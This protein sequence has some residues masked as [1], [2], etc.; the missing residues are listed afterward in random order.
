IATSLNSPM[1][2]RMNA[3]FALT[4]WQSTR[5]LFLE[6]RAHFSRVSPR[7]RGTCGRPAGLLRLL[8]PVVQRVLG[9]S[10]A[11]GHVH[12]REAALEHLLHRL[13]PELI[14]VSLAAHEH[15]CCSHEFWPSGVYKRL[16]G[17]PGSGAMLPV[18]PL[19][20]GPLSTD[21][22]WSW[23]VIPNAD[24]TLIRP[25]PVLKTKSRGLALAIY[26]VI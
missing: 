9:D 26:R 13:G 4:P 1:C 23:W 10:D 18:G 3:Y 20:T 6:C 17:P 19:R 5:R 16:V 25:L 12:H 24:E 2:A 7:R 14:R 21:G 15:L 8:H 11:R 22:H